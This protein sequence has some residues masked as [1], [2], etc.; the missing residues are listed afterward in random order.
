MIKY[1]GLIARKTGQRLM[2]C[3]NNYLQGVDK[4][5]MVHWH[6]VKSLNRI[7][8]EQTKLRAYGMK[9]DDYGMKLRE[10]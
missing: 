2:R 3:G 8:R 6:R 7:C 9:W 1:T 10:V 5:G 4:N